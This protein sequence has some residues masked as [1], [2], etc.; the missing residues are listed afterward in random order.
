MLNGTILTVEEDTCFS[1]ANVFGRS[2]PVWLALQR[3]QEKVIRFGQFAHTMPYIRK[4]NGHEHNCSVSFLC[5]AILVALRPFV[6][7]DE[8]FIMES[9]RIHDIPEGLLGRDIVGPLKSDEHE[10]EEYEAF[11]NLF[12]PLGE[13]FW[14]DAHRHFLLQY[15]RKDHGFLPDDAKAIVQELALDK[16]MEAA[17]WD[18]I[19]RID[20]LYY[21]YEC[22][23]EHHEQLVIGEVV[24][25]QF[26]KID[27]I[28]RL[29]PGFGPVVWDKHRVYFRRCSVAYA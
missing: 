24:E 27:E 21:A 1:G 26:A 6:T 17:V 3:G 22:S 14:N 7:L 10:R 4:Q 15:V 5:R 29:V 9:C 25:R 13:D 11:R 2:Y 16:H 28:A 20:Y 18:G 19:E 23:R 8:A 12:F